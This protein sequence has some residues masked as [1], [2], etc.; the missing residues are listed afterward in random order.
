MFSLDWL[1]L[2]HHK[3]QLFV[4]YIKRI[5]LPIVWCLRYLHVEP[6]FFSSSPGIIWF[7][8]VR[9]QVLTAAS[10]KMAVFRVVAPWSL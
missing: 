7:K 4:H 10:M 5:Y 2:F 3:K 6:C 8:N 1:K 9:F